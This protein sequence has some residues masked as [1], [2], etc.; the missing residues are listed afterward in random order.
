LAWLTIRKYK[1]STQSRFILQGPL[2]AWCICIAQSWIACGAALPL[3]QFLRQPIRLNGPPTHFQKAGTPTAAGLIFLPIACVTSA[4]LCYS[5]R[6]ATISAAICASAALG[7]LD[8]YLTVHPLSPRIRGLPAPIKLAAQTIIAYSVSLCALRSI[9]R[10]ITIITLPTLPP[11]ALSPL[12]YLLLCSFTHVAE[13]NAVNLTDGVDGLAA[14][15][16]S[17]TLACLSRG[18]SPLCEDVAVLCAALSG[19]ICGFWYHNRYPAKAF[20][21]NI[22]AEGIGAAIAAVA[23]VTCSHGAVASLSLV[24]AI[25]AASVIL[26]VLWRKWTAAWSRDG[27]GVSL[28]LMSPL[29][30]HFEMLGWKE[31][32]IVGLAVTVQIVVCLFTLALWTL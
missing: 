22:G 9:Q 19:A 24:F 28:L 10:Q 2:V 15:C 4:F 31:T 32:R 25:E 30:H 8:D 7:F 13:A 12:L 21:G 23:A 26:Q 18:V 1:A 27:E 5:A 20:M 29:H 11:L 14:S 6:A 16:S 3:L 17:I